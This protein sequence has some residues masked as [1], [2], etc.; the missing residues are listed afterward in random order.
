MSPHSLFDFSEGPLDDW[1]REG[2]DEAEVLHSLH[3][4]VDLRRELYFLRNVAQIFSR[5]G[6]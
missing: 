4:S 1:K 5:H 2:L 6:L 3:S